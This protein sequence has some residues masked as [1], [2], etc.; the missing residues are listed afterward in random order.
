[1]E[2]DGGR[3]VQTALDSAQQIAS[4]HD[5]DITG[6]VAGTCR[7]GSVDLLLHT[8]EGDIYA[9]VAGT[10]SIHLTTWAFGELTSWGQTPDLVEVVKFLDRWNSHATLTRL[11]AVFPWLTIAAGTSEAGVID[12][13]WNWLFTVDHQSSAS[14]VA[15]SV[16]QHSALRDHYPFVSH[17]AFALL[18]GPV[19]RSSHAATFYPVIGGGWRVV[20]RDINIA[21]Q[22]IDSAVEQVAH[23][24]TDGWP[25]HR[26]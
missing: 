26:N 12:A 9:K 3:A 16:H 5:L 11:A 1:M 20:G 4:E 21:A 14:V 13:Q 19:T 18:S 15:Q 17:G 22:T 7:F 25:R 10:G 24:V 2:T 8:A 23:A 6:T